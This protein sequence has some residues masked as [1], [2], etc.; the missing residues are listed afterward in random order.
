MNSSKYVTATL[1]RSHACASLSIP[2][3]LSPL[4]SLLRTLSFS[5][6]LH[7]QNALTHTLTHVTSMQQKD[8][9]FI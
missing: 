5:L 6:F 3:S 7:T 4:L 1:S 8:V 9:P 2:H